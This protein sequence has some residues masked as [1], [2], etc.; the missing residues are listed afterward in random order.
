[1]WD[2]LESTKGI[3]NLTNLELHT[4]VMAVMQ[5][6]SFCR[7]ADVAQ[8]KLSDLFY[9]LDYF[10]VNIWYSKTD[11]QGVGQ[12]AFI[13]R[14]DSGI[15]DP[16]NLMCLYLSKMHSNQDDLVFLFPPLK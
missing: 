6:A 10:K 12:A 13:P 9:D 4:F 11:Q 16:H 1:M 14:L 2:K 7:F 8:L 5:H 3:A 15:R